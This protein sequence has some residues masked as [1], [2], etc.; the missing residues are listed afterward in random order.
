MAS[1]SVTRS[2]SAGSTATVTRPAPV[3]RASAPGRRHSRAS[4][5]RPD[6]PGGSPRSRAAARP[7][8][9]ASQPASGSPSSS[10]T[11]YVGQP[12]GRGP[13]DH[14]PQVGGAGREPGRDLPGRRG[15]PDLG[16]DDEQH[17]VGDR[18]SATGRRVQGSGQVH[19]RQ[20]DG[21][22]APQRAPTPSRPAAASV[23]S[24]RCHDSTETPATA[25]SARRSS[26]GSVRPLGADQ[27]RPAQTGGCLDAHARGRG[28]RRAGRRPRAAPA[29]RAAPRSRASAHARVDAPAPPRPPAT[30]STPAGRRPTRHS[31]SRRPAG[32]R[33]RGSG[34]T[35]S[36]PAAAAAR[37]TPSSSRDQSATS[38]EAR[39]GS[40]GPGHGT[41]QVGA[42]QHDRRA[43]PGRPG[44]T[45]V[46]ARPPSRHPRRAASRSRSS[47]RSASPVT[48]R[49][50]SGTGHLR[51]Q[52]T[53]RWRSGRRTDGGAG[54]RS[55]DGGGGQRGLGTT[56]RRAAH[57]RTGAKPGRDVRR[58]PPGGER[59]PSVG[60]TRGGWA[61]PAECAPRGAGHDARMYPEWPLR[62]RRRPAR[63]V[64]ILAALCSD[65]GRPRPALDRPPCPRPAH[66]RVLRP[67][68]DD[69][70]QVEHA[71]LQP[72]VLPGRAD[73]PPGRP[74]QRLRP[75]RLPRRRRR[76]R[77]DGADAGLPVL[78]GHRLGRRAGQGDRRRDAARADR[79]DRSTTRP[80]P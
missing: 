28:R 12:A 1:A 29:R 30:A 33:R 48:S 62:K 20:P 39:R 26:C 65:R 11:E 70:R 35:A 25:G 75:V 24:P 53:S 2:A 59:G 10:A 42:D 43:G 27:V 46:L 54:S 44:R 60:P 14:D 40:A 56:T 80:P 38:T 31:A 55:V 37:H 50:R 15:G 58:P 74:A 79:P 66:R 78:D 36:A 41:D 8:S 7:G 22:C 67:G 45:D 63:V 77:P 69:H 6:R 72:V 73:Q 51:G 13:A 76:P 71:G 49:G 16:R 32:R 34:C 19:D 4:G 64:V 17:D 3:C 61:G 5:P 23:G 18:S 57:R 21:P 68:Q 52:Q 47:S 9:G